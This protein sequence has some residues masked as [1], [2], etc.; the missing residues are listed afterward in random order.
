MEAAP[1]RFLSAFRRT[2]YDSRRGECVTMASKASTTPVSIPAGTVELSGDLTLANDARGLVIFV[3]GSGSSRFSSRN[4]HVAGMLN[5]GGFATL[6]ADLLTPEEEAVDMRSAALRFDIPMLAERTVWMIDWARSQGSV[7]YLPVGLFGASTG[8]AAA[9]IAATQRRDETSAV[10]SRGGRVDLAGSALERLHAPLLMIVGG[11]DFPV[12]ELHERVVSR[13]TCP[14]RYEI[15]Q[16]ATHLFE[17]PGALD[18]VAE[19]ATGWFE[20][21]LAI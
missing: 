19:L 4:R 20:R 9:I 5:A 13:L 8:A 2:R 14:F 7:N 17:E 1:R 15:V 21:Y 18:A 12:M 10:V 6:L 11:L 16:G 3:H